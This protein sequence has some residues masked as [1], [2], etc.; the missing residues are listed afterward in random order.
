MTRAQ[1]FGFTLIELIIVVAI[2]GI[3]S[4]IA[5][6]GYNEQV[7]AARRSDAMASLQGIQLAQEKWRANNPTY[8]TLAE[9]WGGQTDSLDGHY[10]LAIASNTATTYTAT[11]APKAGSTQAADSCGT[12]AVNQDGPDTGT[13]YAEARCWKR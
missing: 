10:T 4:T 3:L 11:A 13:G 1:G 2:I 7:R 9:V 12:Y 5:Y 8:G 6:A